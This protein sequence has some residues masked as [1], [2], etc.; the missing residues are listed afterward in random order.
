[1]RFMGWFTMAVIMAGIGQVHA[2]GPT[3]ASLF[4]TSDD[5]VV[6]E[7]RD[8]VNQGELARAE[9]MLTEAPVLAEAQR[10]RREGLETIRRIRR[11]YSQD[12]DSL[13]AGIRR[14][15]PS[16]TAADVERWRQQGQVQY[17]VL[18]GQVCYFGREPS[19]IWL[20]CTEAKERRARHEGRDPKAAS[21]PSDKERRLFAHLE[22]VIA[23]AEQTGD[24]EVVPIKHTIRYRLSVR[25][26]RPGAK[27]GSLVRCWL[28]FPQEYR[29]QKQVKLLR[30]QPAQHVVAPNAVDAWPLSGAPQRTI[31]LEQKLADPGQAVTFEADFE[32]VS[33]AYY[34]Q[35][36]DAQARP[37]PA[38][39]HGGYLAE[40]PPHIVFTPEIRATVNQIV[41][42]ETN[43]LA[44]ARKIFHWMSRTY[45]W[46]AE[47]EYAI[48][49]NLSEKL[50]KVGRGDCGTHA[51]LYITM[52]RIAGVP[53]RWQSGWETI[54][55]D[56]NMHDWAEVYVEPWGWLPT[57]ISYGLKDSPN[58]RV[59]E[60]FFGHQDAY[61]LIV[62]LDYG[63]DLH[64][65][66]DDLRSEPADFQRGEVEIDGRNL[67]FDEWT[68]RFE[69]DAVRVTAK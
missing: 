54:P 33:F 40:R 39:Y 51:L 49:P 59:H 8:L 52:C 63:W 11:D 46:A 5:A 6:Q 3:G 10:A 34:P 69:F 28:P 2:D 35:L 9:K 38:D 57:D 68:Y 30:T 58:P 21:R 19:N 14:N 26:N 16:V 62:N 27:T 61:R 50:F 42:D 31:Y 12:L 47:Q 24:I 1:M 22:Q 41:G 17:R 60:F 37:L 13:L 66:K 64:P 53:A 20:F 65:P 55:E 36:D 15:L 48:I 45:P 23:E 29:Q 18:D 32:Y 7:A 25:P 4:W 43:P 56:H 44:R 67:Y